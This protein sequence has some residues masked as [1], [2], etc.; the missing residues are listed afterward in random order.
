MERGCIC[1][2]KNA[3]VFFQNNDKSL[4][5]SS[6]TQFKEKRYIFHKSLKVFKDLI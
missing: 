6:S 5:Q 1:S 3:S 4:H 2:S